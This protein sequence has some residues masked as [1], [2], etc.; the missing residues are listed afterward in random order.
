M[1]ERIHNLMTDRGHEDLLFRVEDPNLGERLVEGLRALDRDAERVGAEI[2]QFVPGQIRTM[3]EMGMCFAK[4]VRRV[5]PDFELP[6]V[7]ASWEHHIPS[8]S[9][10]LT[11]LMEAH[12]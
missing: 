10:G 5:Y 12:G 7:P 3:G 6:S 4:E 11:R 2:L 1:D 8:L 9:P